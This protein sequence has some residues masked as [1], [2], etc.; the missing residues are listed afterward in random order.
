MKGEHGE[1]RFV[2]DVLERCSTAVIV[3][4]GAIDALDA[5]GSSPDALHKFNGNAVI[6]PH[7][8]EMARLLGIEPEDISRNPEQVSLDTAAS[9]N[10]VVA[11]KGSRT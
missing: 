8:G 10:A 9:L 7:L 2:L 1:Q 4:A 6:T 3:D 5:L 11:L